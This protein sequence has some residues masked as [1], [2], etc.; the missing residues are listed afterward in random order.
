MW[1]DTHYI[2]KLCRFLDT[3]TE[4]QQV[5]FY[6]GCKL[7][8][9]DTLLI[10]AVISSLLSCRAKTKVIVLGY[11]GLTEASFFIFSKEREVRGCAAI[12]LG[13]TAI[14]KDL[15]MYEAM[16]RRVYLE[17]VRIGLITQEES[18]VIWAQHSSKLLLASEIR[19]RLR[20]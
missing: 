14:I 15:P 13:G 12:G 3:R 17:A 11:C 9:K 5:S 19:Q 18:D 10:G 8:D 7:H 6:V 4:E 1:I 2:N 20:L 16:L